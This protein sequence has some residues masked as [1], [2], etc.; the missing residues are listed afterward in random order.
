[1]KHRFL[2]I[3]QMDKPKV[4][5]SIG[6]GGKRTLVFTRTKRGAD[7]LVEQLD[8]EGVRAGAIHGDLRQQ[9]REKALRQFTDGSVPVLVAT[10]VAAR[11]LHIDNVDTVVH[12]D[13]PE[14]HKTYLH[15][16]GRTARA[17]A[18]GVA[19][20]LVL[21]DQVLEIQKLQ[22][23]LGLDLPMVEVFSNDPRLADLARWES[24]TED[25]LA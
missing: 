1:M 8:R 3:H 18:S 17:G 6:R 16:S 21:W 19:V 24:V 25:A 14:D 10:D 22:K 9:A 2:S 20:T 23:R 13:P 11:G 7:R 4:V 12:F 5:A 15:R